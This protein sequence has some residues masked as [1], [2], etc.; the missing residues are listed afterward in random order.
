MSTDPASLQNLHD[1]VEPMP[2][3]IWWPPEPGWWFLLVIVLAVC[4]WRFMRRIKN[5]HADAYR[6]EALSELE[7]LEDITRL[8][9]LLKRTALVAYPRKTV[10]S[11][12][13]EKS[14][15]GPW[16]PARYGSPFWEDSQRRLTPIQ[17]LVAF[18]LIERSTFL[19]GTGY[20]I[21]P[22]RKRLI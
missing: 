16:P 17:S 21:K 6:R 20:F 11:L 18:G 3:S 13:G 7:R 5:R 14:A 22:G 9:E 10:A 19:S 1:I 4:L 2:G 15:G 8:P 12:A